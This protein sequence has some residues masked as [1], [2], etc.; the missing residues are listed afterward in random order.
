[1][2]HLSLR[3]LELISEV[4]VNVLYD[5]LCRLRLH[6]GRH[7]ACKIEG[8]IAIQVHFVVY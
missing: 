6:P 7:K 1:V 2:Y 8:R 4:L 5:K 3:I